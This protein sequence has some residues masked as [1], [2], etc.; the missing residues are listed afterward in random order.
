MG[1]TPSES[2]GPQSRHCAVAE[3]CNLA[4]AAP[5]EMEMQ[6]AVAASEGSDLANEWGAFF[7]ETSART[8]ANTEEA[9]Q[10]GIAEALPMS[11]HVAF[12]HLPERESLGEQGF[13]C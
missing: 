9:L 10:T 13:C 6:R 11:I 3:E 4:R 7:F 8:G 12:P 5:A 2:A 1:E